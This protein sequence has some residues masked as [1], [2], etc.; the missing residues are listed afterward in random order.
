MKALRH[1]IVL[2]F[3]ITHLNALDSQRIPF[4][5]ALLCVK[6]LVY[7]HLITHYQY[8]TEAT[9][10]F[11]QNYWKNFHYH[12]D[13]F[14]QFFA[15][16]STMRVWE[17]LKNQLTLNKQEEQESD[18]TSNNLSMAAK[19]YHVVDDTM[20]IMSELAQ[21]LVDKL[22]F[23]LDTMHFLNQFS[24]RIHQVGDYWNA[25]SELPERAMIDS[26][27]AY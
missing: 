4:T 20:L 24:N 11:M 27:H 15:S 26:T 1:I 25:R 3:T 23:Y 5:E 10:K 16:K 7:F 8:H 14:S 6:N 2:V 9:I 13:V 22:D 12:K 18:S 19:C 17:A 21:H